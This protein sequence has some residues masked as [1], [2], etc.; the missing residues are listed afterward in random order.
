MRGVVRQG[1]QHRHGD[2]RHRHADRLH[3][4][5]GREEGG[6]GTAIQEQKVANGERNAHE[7]GW[8]RRLEGRQRPHL[9]TFGRP[10]AR[11]GARHRTGTHRFT[12]RV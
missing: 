7:R 8:A 4:P 11:G 5:P 6:G 9:A 12:T 10:R 1:E 2:T 3:A